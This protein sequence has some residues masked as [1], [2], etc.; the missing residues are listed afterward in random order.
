MSDAPVSEDRRDRSEPQ[1][2]RARTLS[3]ALTV[4]DIRASLAWYCDKVGFHL[5]EKYEQDGELRGAS[6][7]AGDVTLVISQ[8]DGARGMD[9]RKGE[10]FRLYFSTARDVDQVAAD[11]QARGGTLAAPPR[12]MPWGVRAFELVDP[13]GFKM[14]IAQLDEGS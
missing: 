13:D 2:F 7:V 9:R 12:D 8:D 4:G 1:A 11:I 6:L 5:E 3:A 10:G 14:T